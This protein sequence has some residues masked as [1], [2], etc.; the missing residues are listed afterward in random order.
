[1][2]NVIKGVFYGIV[3]TGIVMVATVFFSDN[4]LTKNR[5]S[6]GDEPIRPDLV[7]VG[8]LA[9]DFDLPILDPFL[10]RA[11][12]VAEGKHFAADDAVK[13][14]TVKLSSFRNKKPVVIISASYT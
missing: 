5:L 2:K 13:L 8:Q 1:M 9:P 6:R 11:K 12:A 10:E 3:A 7:Q 14:T 4:D